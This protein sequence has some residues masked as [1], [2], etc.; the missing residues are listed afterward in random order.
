MF[1]IIFMQGTSTANLPLRWRIHHV[2]R[3]EKLTRNSIIQVE[4]ETYSPWK[5]FHCYYCKCNLQAFDNLQKVIRTN[6][7]TVI[8]FNISLYENFPLRKSLGAKQ[9]LRQMGC[10][11]DE[12][13]TNLI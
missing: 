2:E 5:R 8:T 11:Y 4:Q 6:Q 9:Q 12:I 13:P 10:D 7:L 1:D 3:G